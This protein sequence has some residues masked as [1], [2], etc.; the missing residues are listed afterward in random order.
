VR[1][2]PDPW[3]GDLGP[4]TVRTARQGYYGSISFVDEQ[5]GRILQALSDRGWLSNTVIFFLADHGDMLGDQHLWRKGYA[6]QPSARIPMLLHWPD[7]LDRTGAGQVISKPVEIRDVLPTLLDAAGA[8][9]P[10]AVEGRS[11]LS[12]AR[13]S[14]RHWREWIDMEHD[15]VYNP[16]NH[17]NALTDGF[18]KYI[19]HANSGQEQLFHIDKDPFEITDLS[20]HAGFGS[21]LS[22][23][24]GRLVAHLAP[25]GEPWVVRGRLGVRHSGRLYSPNYRV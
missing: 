22:K 14:N 13:D 4:E 1:Y 9:V 11:L 24:R 20:G 21:E 23:W 8:P 25:R 7:G 5:I 18:S 16:N 10:Q 15:I 17:W 3:H 2:L 19:Y 12:L 6:Y